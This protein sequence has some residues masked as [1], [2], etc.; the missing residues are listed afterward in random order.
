MEVSQS[1]GWIFFEPQID[2]DA[3]RF[4][5]ALCFGLCFC[6]VKSALICGCFSIEGNNRE[7]R[8]SIFGWR[9]DVKGSESTGYDF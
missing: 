2:A 8:L 9:G 5:G 6:S 4:D 1:R 3:R 7:S